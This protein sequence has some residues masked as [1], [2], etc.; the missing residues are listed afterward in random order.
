M[1]I[2]NSTN[3]PP[4]LRGKFRKF[5]YAPRPVDLLW[6]L[7]FLILLPEVI[8]FFIHSW[9]VLTWEWQIDFDEGFNLDAS[10]KLANGVNIYGQAQPDQFIAA[11]YPP[12]YYILCAAFQKVFGYGMLGGR[13][14]SFVSSLAIGLF[15]FLFARRLSLTYFKLG[16]VDAFLA[17]LL[18]LFTWLSLNVTLVWGTF[19]KQD[20]LAM[21]LAIAGLWFTWRW[22]DQEIGRWSMLLAAGLLT[23]GFYTKQNELA[24]LGVGWLYVVLKDW[25]RG[26]KFGITLAVML[27]VPFLV[28]DLLTKH[29]F[30]FD[31]FVA[32]QVPWILDD[33]LRR[34]TTRILPDHLLLI[35]LALVF[36]LLALNGL[37]R[38]WAKREWHAPHMVLIW[39]AGG[40]FTLITVGSYQS[41]Y[42]HALN[43][44]PPVVVGAAGVM[45]WLISLAGRAGQGQRQLAFGL[46]ALAVAGGLAWQF[47]HYAD[48]NLYYSAGNMPSQVRREMLEGLVKQVGQA[49][50]DILSEDIYLQLK[51]G[52]PVIYDDLYHM[53]LQAEAGQWD[54]SRFVA[55][56]KARRFSVIL[57]GQGSRRFTD[58]GWEALNANYRLIFPDGIALWRPRPQP[59]LPQHQVDCEVGN[60]FAFKGV[61]YGRPGNDRDLNLTTYWQ[62]QA[63]AAENYTFFVHLLDPSGKV[64]AQRDAPPSG[65]RIANPQ[66]LIKEMQDLPQTQEQPLPAT[67]W[68]SGDSMLINQ[69]LPLPAGTKLTGDYRL[70]VGAYSLKS[71]GELNS[72]AVSCATPGAASENVINLP[73]PR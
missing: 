43:F 21:A 6:L 52:R 63:K 37:V 12:V 53:A 13:L 68:A 2:I 59:L 66:A 26:L 56:L 15:I 62:A 65:W 70:I 67:T 57:L 45:A 71:N 10:W 32:Q 39:L 27:A 34:L 47:Y 14:I 9:Q 25:R 36:S 4:G 55:D 61:S 64:V 73:P 18:G 16:R 35:V 40:T 22:V 7:L 29:R 33:F 23:L 19:F 46:A 41:G 69:T 17:G 54:E 8:R 44:F 72:L 3:Q 50:G 31:V 51:T 30:Y 58:T 49:P 20:M 42:N 28:L 60:T 24:A 48:S 5:S 38:K 1:A 11:P